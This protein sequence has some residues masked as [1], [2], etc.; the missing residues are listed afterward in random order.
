M[1]APKMTKHA[2]IG[3][4]WLAGAFI[5]VA[6]LVLSYHSGEIHLSRRSPFDNTGSGHAEQWIF[7]SEA[8]GHIPRGASFTVLAEDRATEMSLFMMSVGLMPE[9]LP[10][11]SSY[12]GQAKEAGNLARFVLEFGALRE[13]RTGESPVATVT[14]G[15]VYERRVHRP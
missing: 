10:L 3:A 13:P 8:A 6:I 7:L 12:Y 9:G 1:L 14:G 11:P 15:R 5:S 2:A 4:V